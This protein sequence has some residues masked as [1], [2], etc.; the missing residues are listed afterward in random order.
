MR[1]A[2]AGS[3]QATPK[4]ISRRKEVIRF[5]TSPTELCSDLTP[6]GPGPGRGN[7]TFVIRS[8]PWPTRGCFLRPAHNS[9]ARSRVNEGEDVA[10]G[11]Q[12]AKGPRHR[13][14]H[15]ACEDKPRANA[16]IGPR[17]GHSQNERAHGA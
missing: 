4:A 5:I 7:V 14:S 15:S 3:E 8:P 13:K 12:P 10:A 9:S 2:E 1:C 6:T 17:L 16:V 11:R